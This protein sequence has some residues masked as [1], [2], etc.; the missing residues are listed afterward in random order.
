MGP[1]RGRTVKKRGYINK[2]RALQVCACVRASGEGMTFAGG[3]D[4]DEKAR[5][6][7]RGSGRERGEQ[8]EAT[9]NDVARNEWPLLTRP[10]GLFWVSCEPQTGDR[11]DAHA[12]APQSL[13]FS[14]E[15][16]WTCHAGQDNKYLLE[17]MIRCTY[18]PSF[19]SSLRFHRA[20]SLK[21]CRD[22]SNG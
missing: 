19:E 8:T 22:D 7:W 18:W 14:R 1:A 11:A 9:N 17:F 16:A 3:Q 15:G 12:A 21:R 4:Q 5:P 20:R 2:Q 10:G 6:V 13:E